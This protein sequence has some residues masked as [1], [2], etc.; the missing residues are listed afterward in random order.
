MIFCCSDSEKDILKE[1]LGNNYKR[2]KKAAL[3]VLSKSNGKVC[4]SNTTA[5]ALLYS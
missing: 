5:I 1:S 2:V 3:E 4:Q